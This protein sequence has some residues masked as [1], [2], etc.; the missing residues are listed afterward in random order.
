MSDTKTQL[1]KIR[2]TSDSA[3]G[4]WVRV[5]LDDRD[6][7]HICQGVAFEADVDGICRVTLQVVASDVEIDVPALLEMYGPSPE[8]PDVSIEKFLQS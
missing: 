1:A 2:I 8:T 7:S 5:E 6:I 3:M 4:R